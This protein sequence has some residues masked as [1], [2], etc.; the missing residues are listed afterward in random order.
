MLHVMRDLV[1]LSIFDHFVNIVKFE[2]IL[3]SRKVSEFDFQIPL[4]TGR[5]HGLKPKNYLVKE[6][7]H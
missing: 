4:G 6:N 3:S 2:K 5:N 1:F 7:P